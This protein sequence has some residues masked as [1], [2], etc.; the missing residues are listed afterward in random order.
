M[1]RR[2]FIG[3]LG[4]AAAAW[5]LS[6]RAQPGERMR[7]IGALINLSADDPEGQARIA[8]FLQGLQE[9]GWAVGRNVQIDIR[10]GMGD[11]ERIR[12]N[13]TELVGLTPD[14]IVANTFPLVAALQQATRVV[15][16]VFAGL[17]D[18]VGAGLVASLARPG[19]NITGFSGFEYGMS[20]KWLEMLKQIAP[21]MTRVA[22]LRDSAHHRGDRPI[23]RNPGRSALVRS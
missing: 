13:V 9:A 5:P 4:G 11:A 20:V 1:K 6:V 8:A 14:V 17:I 16:V 23:G 3:L 15:P 22:V 12:K 19:G 18:P 7:R 21:R 10:W 2:A